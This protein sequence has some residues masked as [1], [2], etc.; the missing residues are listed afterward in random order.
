MSD[1]QGK[2][3]TK[4]KY[5]RNEAMDIMARHSRVIDLQVPVFL[6]SD[7]MRRQIEHQGLPLF[8][9]QLT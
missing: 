8:G 3:N 5:N 4:A 2:F 9:E 6:I 7:A 1:G